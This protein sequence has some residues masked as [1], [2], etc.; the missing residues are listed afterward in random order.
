MRRPR[1][2]VAAV[3]LTLLGAMMIGSPAQA[4]ERTGFAS[5]FEAADPQPDWTDTTVRACGVD[6]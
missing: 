4:T 2:A 3:P 1:W 5:S 6:G